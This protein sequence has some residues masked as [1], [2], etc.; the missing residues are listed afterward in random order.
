MFRLEREKEKKFI[1]VYIN[2]VYSGD[3]SD[4]QIRNRGILVLNMISLFEQNHIGV[5]LYAFEASCLKDEIFI[6]DIRLKSGNVIILCAERN[7]SAGFWR[8]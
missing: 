7:L 1:D 4:E 8:G 3:T 5:N 2:L 6:A